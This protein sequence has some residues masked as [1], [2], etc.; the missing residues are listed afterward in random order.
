MQEQD[1]D[2]LAGAC[3]LW[4]RRK[5]ECKDRVGRVPSLGLPVFVIAQEVVFVPVVHRGFQEQP[6]HAQMSHFLETAVGGVDAAADDT[7]ALPLHLLA[8]Q[9]VLGKENLLMKSAEF[10]E[11]FQVEKHEHSRGEGMMEAREVLEEIVS[12]VKQL[13]DPV[14]VAAKDIR[15]DTMKLLALGQFDGAA[16]DR[17]MCQFDVGIKKENV[18]A[19]GLGCSQIAAD[20]GH[21]A[22]DHA[23]VQAVA[24]AEN[25]IA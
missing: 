8:E 6:A 24:E 3:F 23:D 20:G 19:L 12:G 10:V 11:P 7:E 4:P 2:W 15:G 14:A 22:T 5:P 1:P 25:N 18:D 17:G 9:V 13:V 16:H 21:S